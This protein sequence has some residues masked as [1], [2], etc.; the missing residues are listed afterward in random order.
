MSR[1]HAL[2]SV[3]PLALTIALVLHVSA[4]QAQQVEEL[5]AIDVAGQSEAAAPAANVPVSGAAVVAP[6]PIVQ[7]YQ[8]P[9]MVDSITAQRIEETINIVDPEDAVKY[10]PSL[11]VRKRNEGDN[12]AVLATRTWGL[13]SSARTLIYADDILLSTLIGNNN[14]YAAPHW[15]L[16]A[17]ESIERIDF[18]EGPFAAAYPGNS[19]GGVMLITTKMPDKLT[20]TAKQTEALQHF[21]LYGTD[22][23]Y[24]TDQTSATIGDRI[25][26]FS[27]F[28]SANYQN[29]YSQPLTYTTNATP[30]A[31]TLG[32]FGALTKQGLPADVVGTGALLHTNEVSANLKLALD[33]TPWLRGT[34]QI[35]FWSYDA[36]SSPQTYLTSTA[37]GGPTFGKVSGFASAEYTWLEQHL[38][39]AVSLRSDTRGALDFD[40]SASTYDYLTD[41]QRNPFSVTPVGVGFTQNGRITRLDGT[42]WENVDFKGIWRP[43]G[44]NG[45]NEVSFGLHGDRYYL[46]NPTYQTTTWNAGSNTGTGFLYSDGLGQTETGGLWAQDVW[47]IIPD[48]KLTLGG[49]LE[50][51]KASDGFNLATTQNTTVGSP[52][53]GTIT[54][55]KGTYQPEL[56]AVDF[57]PKASLSWQPNKEWEI[58]GSFGDAYRYPTVQEL[59]A[60]STSGANYVIPNPYLTPE[61]DLVGEIDIERKWEDGKVRLSL[62]HENTFNALISQTNTATLSN[63]AQGT[64]SSVANVAQTQNQGVELS[65]QKDN[66]LIR[67]MQIFGSVTY[68]DSHILSDPT[69]AGT[70][71][72]TGLPDSVVGKHV[73]YVPVFRSTFGMTYRPDPYWAFTL[74]A[75]YSGKQYSTLDNTDVISNV[76]GAFDN[77]F[78]VDL[79]VHYSVNDN[80]S[81]DFGVDNLNNET[82]FLFHPFPK[83]TFVADA[84]VK[85]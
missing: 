47:K 52:T 72:F 68:V 37:T 63:G 7:K 31:G 4:A 33:F 43:F 9:V 61:Q 8:L 66:V 29:S 1:N 77:F 30:P 74:A 5:P 21:S 24:R 80:V 10:M 67:G 57:S 26:I 58:T 73:P 32:T 83:R 15:N 64:V 82:Y 39:N 48:L 2:R 69:W 42:N 19:M 62:F 50:S 41:I 71:P 79:R 18:L 17:P 40:I 85:F 28:A 81:L 59:Y 3:S 65:A 13:N 11:F 60:I 53:V 38:A 76:Y 6:P 78:V 70:N 12:Q 16:V 25:G 49:R 22:A 14:S 84:K 55:S 27:W 54:S 56:H 23:N 46:N 36:S 34:Y 75:R 20:M 45:A 44:V 35:G 51:W